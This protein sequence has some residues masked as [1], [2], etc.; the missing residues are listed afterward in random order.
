MLPFIESKRSEVEAACRR[1]AVRRLDLFGSAVRDDFD[2]V[3]SAWIS[4]WNST[5]LR[6]CRRWS[7]ISD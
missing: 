7:S 4:W 5:R 2:P 6:L 1:P 3:E